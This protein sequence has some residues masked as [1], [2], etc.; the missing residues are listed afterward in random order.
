MLSITDQT[1]LHFSYLKLCV[2]SFLK[3]SSLKNE[4]EILLFDFPSACEVF[5]FTSTSRLK[6][7]AI[8]ACI[9]R[10]ILRESG[11]DLAFVV[12]SC[13]F[14]LGNVKTMFMSA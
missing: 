1:F 13:D 6:V 2:F 9:S 12:L 10:Y 8:S 3:Q 11:V 5:T 14:L 4:N 7:L